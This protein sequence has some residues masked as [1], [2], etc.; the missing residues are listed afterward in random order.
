VPPRPTPYPH[1]SGLTAV[2]RIRLV[3]WSYAA[4]AA[5][6]AAVLL[7]GAIADLR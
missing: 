1:R 5:S 3:K 2:T 6:G 7:V 4:I